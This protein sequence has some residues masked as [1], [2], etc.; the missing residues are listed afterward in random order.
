MIFDGSAKTFVIIL[1][2]TTFADALVKGGT[3]DYAAQGNY[4]LDTSAVHVPVGDAVLLGSFPVGFDFA[5]NAANYQ[6]TRAAFT[7]YDTTSIGIGT[8]NNN[9]AG[10]FAASIANTDTLGAANNPVYM[11]LFN[12]SNPATATAWAIISNPSATWRVPADGSFNSTSIDASDVNTY[13]PTGARGA[14]VTDSTAPSGLGVSVQLV[15][16][17]SVYYMLLFF[18]LAAGT[19]LAK[20]KFSLSKGCSDFSRPLK[21][22]IY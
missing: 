3:L 18:A 17:P 8:T 7:L 19:K 13:V 15:P 14:L 21:A 11:W 5:T 4:I 10:Q 22:F 12:S 20:Q 1:L 9:V 16:E 2:C 6:N